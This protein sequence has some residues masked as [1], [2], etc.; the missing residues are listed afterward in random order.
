MTLGAARMRDDTTRRPPR[1]SSSRRAHLKA[2]SMVVDRGAEKSYSDS[3]S[4]RASASTSARISSTSTQSM[5]SMGSRMYARQPQV[6][7]RRAASKPMAAPSTLRETRILIRDC[8]DHA[9]PS[10]VSSAAVT[11]RTAVERASNQG[12][13]TTVL[14]RRGMPCRPQRLQPP[15]RRPKK[16]CCAACAGAAVVGSLPTR[17]S[18]PPLLPLLLPPRRPQQRA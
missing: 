7:R 3:C 13:R 16:G 15:A 12:V 6:A 1:H 8:S 4:S 18:A 11:A 9:C 17:P 5:R 10:T 14:R 2:R